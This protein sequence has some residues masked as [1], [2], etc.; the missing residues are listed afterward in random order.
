MTVGPGCVILTVT[1]PPDGQG[2]VS[3]TADWWDD[4]RVY[5]R[6]GK[7][8]V[9]GVNPGPR[10][11]CFHSDVARHARLW[12]NAGHRVTIIDPYSQP[13]GATAPSGPTSTP[14]LTPGKE[15]RT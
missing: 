3:F 10:A 13:P 5:D 15:E 12:A 2:R 9:T 14:S 11:Q 1:S 8:F 7:A 6:A 4:D